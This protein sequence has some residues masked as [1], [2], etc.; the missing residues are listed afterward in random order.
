MK[1]QEAALTF[2]VCHLSTKAEQTDLK[3]TF[4]QFDKNNNGTISKEE[5]LV[6]YQEIYKDQLS[7]EE[8]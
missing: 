6:G 2:M 4:K 5:L 8:I 1:L 3:A 7:V